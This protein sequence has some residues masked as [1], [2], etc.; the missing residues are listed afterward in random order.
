[1]IAY[2]LA[3][4]AAA[5]M[6]I[7]VLSAVL[8]VALFAL[9]DPVDIMAPP[10]AT[11]VERTQMR[12]SLGLDR[13]LVEQY[14]GFLRGLASGDLGQ[15][16]VYKRPVRDVI[17]ERMPATVELALAAFVLALAVG[18]PL[19]MYAGVRP[20]SRLARAVMGA[21]ILGISLPSFWI[22]ILLILTF[23]V[24][25]GWLP[26]GG[27]GEGVTV[28][29]IEFSLLTLDGLAHLALPALNLALFK[30]ALVMR[31]TRAGTREIVLLDYVRFA[32]AKG[33]APSRVYGVH[34]LKNL[35]I[36]VVTVLG[37][38]FGNMIAYTTVTETIFS[39]PG[40]GKLLI[41]SINAL[42][43]PVVVAY[44]M[45]IVTLFAILNLIVDLSYLVLDPRLRGGG[46]AGL[47][48]KPA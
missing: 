14:A 10:E 47:T 5:L 2:I 23:G 6:T 13:P 16:F 3:R 18:I 17:F 43:R 25:L 33:L 42:D 9:G 30:I 19:G 27:R 28:A 12:Q 22:G 21:S 20:A 15:S 48:G 44:I 38:E 26:T 45:V 46:A 8:F 4:V 40:I 41:D 36:P 37:L 35:M 24:W 29:G 7:L 39:W 31:L 11:E 1:M 32:R 34:V